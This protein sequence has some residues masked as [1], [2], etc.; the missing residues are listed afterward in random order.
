MTEV[1]QEDFSKRQ[2]EVRLVAADEPLKDFN[3]EQ[4]K[5]DVIIGPELCAHYFRVI[6]TLCRDSHISST[7]VS[8][9]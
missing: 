6:P 9:V 1:S 5:L 8:Q 7:V 3:T 4:D 2:V